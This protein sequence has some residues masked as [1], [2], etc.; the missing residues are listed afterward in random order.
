MPSNVP[1]ASNRIAAPQ[2]GRHHRLTWLVLGILIGLP[3]GGAGT[4][5]ALVSGLLSPSD[6]LDSEA[7]SEGPNP[8]PAA[9]PDECLPRCTKVHE[10]C[11]ELSTK[12]KR[13]PVR[14]W[15]WDLRRNAIASR[16]AECDRDLQACNAGCR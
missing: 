5:A 14:S 6:D 7:S 9:P 4:Y 13:T 3:V 11:M 15:E 12:F 2:R 10:A 8:T 1:P 16:R